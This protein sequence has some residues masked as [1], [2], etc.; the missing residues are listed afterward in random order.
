[1]SKTDQ[2]TKERRQQI[3]EDFSR[4]HNGQFDPKLFL[5]EIEETGKKHAAYSWFEWD[6]AKAAKEHRLWQ[7]RS[8]AKDL[9][10]HFTIEE[11]GRQG[12]I[13]MKTSEMP[14]VISPADGRNDGGGYVQVDPN[15]PAHMTEHCH[16]AA[17]ALRSWLRRYQAAIVHVYN[18][19]V[20][21]G[22]I[23]DALDSVKAPEQEKAA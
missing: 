14:M 3:V 20:L 19:D 5:K 18:S 13:T 21:V 2:F 6:N 8:F 11:V 22:Q 10:I 23:V 16:Q 9:R 12:A 17:T 1:M 4:R 7:A 15:N